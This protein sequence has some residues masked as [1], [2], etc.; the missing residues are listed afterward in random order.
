[1]IQRWVLVVVRVEFGRVKAEMLGISL[2][3]AEGSYLE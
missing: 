3:K 2:A 1:M